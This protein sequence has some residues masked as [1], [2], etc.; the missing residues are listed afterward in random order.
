MTDAAPTL[1]D[2]VQQAEESVFAG[3]ERELRR[4]IDL[5]TDPRRLPLTVSLTGPPGIGKTAMLEECARRV[6]SVDAGRTVLI[7]CHE[8]DG[9]VDGFRSMLGRRTAG[10]TGGGVEV[11]TLLGVD[12]YELLTVPRRRRLR[13]EFLEQLTGPVLV[14]LADRKGPVDMLSQRAG[15]RACMETMSLGPLDEVEARRLLAGRGLSDGVAVADALRLAAGHPLVLAVAADVALRGGI[16][17]LPAWLIAETVTRML[18]LRLRREARD[19]RLAEL[20]VASSLMPVVD[21]D[22]LSEMLDLDLSNLEAAF[23]DLS[24]VEVVSDGY[25]IREPWRHLLGAD[26]LRRR[27]RRHAQL[28]ARAQAHRLA[29]SSS[30][31]PSLSSARPLRVVG[32]PGWALALDAGGDQESAR[33]AVRAA[34]DGAARERVKLVLEALDHPEAL[35]ERWPLDDPRVAGGV[36]AMGRHLQRRLLDIIRTL[37]ASRSPRVSQAGRVLHC[38]YVVRTGSLEALAERLCVSRA[39]LFRR[40]SLGLTLVYERLADGELDGVACA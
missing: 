12:S 28:V 20:L 3:R 38:Y 21:S 30:P 14:V 16:R 6:R 26:L 39:T 32:T 36:E 29:H 34:V 22:L 4:L 13:E 40:L 7:D 19:P 11:P 10:W 27:P 18:H 1:R 9:S 5:M 15:W 37:A 33:A 8:F 17:P 25:A 2:R 24:V 23:A 31:S 35:A